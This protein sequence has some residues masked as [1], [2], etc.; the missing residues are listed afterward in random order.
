MAWPCA[1]TADHQVFCGDEW[2]KVPVEPIDR[3][4]GTFNGCGITPTGA[5]RCWEYSFETH[6]SSPTT[7]PKVTDASDLGM[8]RSDF[9]IVRARGA[10]WCGMSGRSRE[11]LVIPSGA[12]DVEVGGD[13]GGDG[14]KREHGCAIM[15]DR[16]VQCWGGNYAGELGDGSITVAADPIGLRL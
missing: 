14:P 7:S 3:I 6:K 1:V 11:R 9:C 15:A 5:V 10:V 8:G 4:S 13:I 12:I 2:S 16:S